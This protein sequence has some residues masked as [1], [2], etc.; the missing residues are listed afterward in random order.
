MPF[1]AVIVALPQ[2]KLLSLKL[3][4]TFGVLGLCTVLCCESFSFTRTRAR[5]PALSHSHSPTL[6]HGRTTMTM[7]A[8][9]GE[10]AAGVNESAQKS[11]RK[12]SPD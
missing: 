7:P 5:V 10:A 12:K 2:A 9:A 6:P 11:G 1:P 3:C 4:G 8:V